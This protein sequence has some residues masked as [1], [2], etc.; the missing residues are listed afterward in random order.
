MNRINSGFTLVEVIVV[1][2]IVGMMSSIAVI[3]FSQMRIDVEEKDLLDTDVHT[4]R[5]S[6][7]RAQH[8]TLYS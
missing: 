6:I 1:A 3:S 7:R 8:H 4:V 5:T 2:T